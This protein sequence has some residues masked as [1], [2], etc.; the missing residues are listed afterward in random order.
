MLTLCLLPAK[1]ENSSSFTK[2]DFSL[3]NQYILEMSRNSAIFGK[4]TFD[5]PTVSLPSLSAN[6]AARK[7]KLENTSVFTVTEMSVSAA[8]V[9]YDYETSASAF[10]VM[11]FFA[12]KIHFLTNTHVFFAS[13]SRDQLDVGQ[14]RP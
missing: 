10:T 8:F 12:L 11:T 9:C 3:L 5:T 2:S 14:V 6:C 7:M 4:T 13:S 1:R